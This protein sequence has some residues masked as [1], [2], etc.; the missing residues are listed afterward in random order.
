MATKTKNDPHIVRSRVEVFEVPGEPGVLGFKLASK[1]LFAVEGRF[2]V[3]FALE[4]IASET[5]ALLSNVVDGRSLGGTPFSKGGI[6]LNPRWNGSNKTAELYEIMS[7]CISDAVKEEIL[8]M[9]SR[10]GSLGQRTVSEGLILIG[11]KMEENQ[12]FDTSKG[13]R[14]KIFE[15][16]GRE[17]V[18][19]TRKEMSSQETSVRTKKW[20]KLRRRTVLALYE[21]IY[22]RLKKLKK[23]CRRLGLDGKGRQGA[24]WNRWRRLKG[25]NADLASVLD[26]L[27]HGNPLELALIYVCHQLSTRA[28]ENVKK[29]IKRAKKERKN[30]KEKASI[31]STVSRVVDSVAKKGETK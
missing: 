14:A 2:D 5:K 3:A 23:T 29:E 25:D 26:L 1:P 12:V 10:M 19:T 13:G 27:P 7:E 8:L 18:K 6:K 21:S 15:A 11:L 20:T 22:K 4:G 28:Y 30:L 9:L 17:V 31:E 16:Y 24:D